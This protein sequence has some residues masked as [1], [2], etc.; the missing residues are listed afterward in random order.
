MSD[1]SAPPPQ[2]VVWIVYDPDEPRKA[3]NVVAQTAFEAWRESATPCAFH[4]AI[5]RVAYDK[6]LRKTK[7]KR[8]RKRKSA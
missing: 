8:G 7:G 3:R 5:V 4:K 6:P 1:A 2:P